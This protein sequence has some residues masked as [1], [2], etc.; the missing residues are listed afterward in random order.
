MWGTIMCSTI[1][2]IMCRTIIYRANE[3][4]ATR[5]FVNASLRA[6]APDIFAA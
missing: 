6:E 1:I 4:W 2:S 5:P 3:T